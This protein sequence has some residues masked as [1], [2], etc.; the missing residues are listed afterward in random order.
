MAPDA[1]RAELTANLQSFVSSAD[2][3]VLTRPYR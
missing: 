2:L 1:A 3:S